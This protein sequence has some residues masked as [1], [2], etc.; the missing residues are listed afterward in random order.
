MIVF[1]AE[2]LSA[3][4]A[5]LAVI[6]I[7]YTGIN[8]ARVRGETK[9]AAPAVTGHPKLDCA[10]RVQLNTIEQA[11]LFFPLLWI[12]TSYFHMLAWLPAVFGL[13]WI[14]GRFLYMQG[15]MAAPD[16]R[17]TGFLITSLATL[18]LLILSV[19]G[20]VQAWIAVHAV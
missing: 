18:G 11:V 4:V 19:I 20:I 2:L 17:S 5:V 12:S 16:K 1:P 7:F 3:A 13:I 9:I 6:F 10:Y 15:Y 14:V 8:V